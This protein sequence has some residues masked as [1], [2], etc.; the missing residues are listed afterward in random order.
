MNGRIVRSNRKTKVYGL[1]SSH[2][3]RENLIELLKER[4]NLHKDKF[5]SPTLHKEM[6]GLEIKRN[7][8]VEHSDLTHDDQI[9]SYLK[10]LYVWYEGKNLRE[11]YGIE[12][13]TIQTEDSVDDIIELESANDKASASLLKPMAAVN[14]DTN[15]E[16]VNKLESQLQQM[17]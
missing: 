12:K 6:T 11:L 17:Q 4:V 5:I 15:N 8:K 16:E 1:D 13:S 7:G 9:F 3:V 2:H 10:A 14:R